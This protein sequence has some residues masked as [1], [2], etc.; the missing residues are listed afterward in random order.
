MTTIPV[1]PRFVFL[2]IILVA[3]SM[4]IGVFIGG[5]SSRL[6]QWCKEY[7]GMA[8][9]HTLQHSPVKQADLISHLPAYLAQGTTLN[10]AM[11]RE[12]IND[13]VAMLKDKQFIFET[14]SG[15]VLTELGKELLVK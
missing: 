8:I 5:L 11:I 9:L 6:D 10:Q 15:L 1:D 12:H 3:M 7:L 14:E 4:V 13:A 2:T